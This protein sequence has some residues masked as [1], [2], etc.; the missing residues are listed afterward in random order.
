MK[1]VINF[2][3]PSKVSELANDAGYVTQATVVVNHAFP[4]S[5]DTTSIDDIIDSV[6]LD[7][8]AIA[9]KSYIGTV[10]SQGLPTGLTQAE[11]QVQI[12][13]GS[14]P[15]YKIIVLSI[16]SEDISPYHWE[17]V[18]AYGRYGEWRAFVSEEDMIK[19]IVAT[20]LPDDSTDTVAKLDAIGFTQ[21]EILAASQGK[22]IG[23]TYNGRFYNIQSVVYT[24]D[25]NYV[26]RFSSFALYKLPPSLQ[27]DTVYYD[28]CEF[29]SIKRNGSYVGCN[30]TSIAQN[31]P[32]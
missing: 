28:A 2:C 19:P 27:D 24:S 20:G 30:A 7:D 16:L 8:T 13:A 18:A 22:R 29:Y 32:V 3:G 17:R 11:L 25:T 12:T 31:T 23:V 4:T 15:G 5:W 14:T 21:E 26:L 1:N 9:G 10:S 6:Q